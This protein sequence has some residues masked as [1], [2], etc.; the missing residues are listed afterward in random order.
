M[1]KDFPW[2][3]KINIYDH[4]RQSAN[5]NCCPRHIDTEYATDPSWFRI[6]GKVVRV[7]RISNPK[8]AL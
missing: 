8:R 6:I 4:N 3:K 7:A 2:E 1:F 5:Q